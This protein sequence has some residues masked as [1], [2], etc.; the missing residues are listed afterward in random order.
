[1]SAS[2]SGNDGTASGMDE[3]NDEP[4]ESSGWFGLDFSIW[5]VIFG[6]CITI[7]GA[8]IWSFV[9]IEKGKQLQ[10]TDREWEDRWLNQRDKFSDDLILRIRRLEDH[11]MKK[12]GN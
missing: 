6:L 1:M 11:Q 8:L 4:P 7:A 9:D 3:R 2:K 10:T 5:A 12:G